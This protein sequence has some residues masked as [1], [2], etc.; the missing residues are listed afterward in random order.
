MLLPGLTNITQ[1]S[2]VPTVSL[3]PH[4]PPLSTF[5]NSALDGTAQTPAPLISATPVIV[6]SHAPLPLSQ[7]PL[8]AA[9]ICPSAP[10]VSQIPRPRTAAQVNNDQ[11]VTRTDLSDSFINIDSPQAP[12]ATGAST[13]NHLSTCEALDQL[14]TAAAQIT[15]NVPTVQTIDQIIG[16]ASDQFQAQQLCVQREIQE[17]VESTNARFAALAEQMQQLISTIAAAAAVRNRPTPRLSPVTSRFHGEETRN[18]Y[19]PNET[20]CETEPAQ[21]FCRP[22]IHDKPKAPSTDTL[23][24]NKF[25]CTTRREEEGSHSAPLRRLQPVANTFAFSDYPPDDYYDHP[26]PRYELPRTSHGEEDSRIKT[27]V[28]NMHRLTINGAATN[29]RLLRFFIRMENEF[30]Y[31]AS[32]HIKMS[33]LRWLSRDMPSDMIQD[34]TPYEDASHPYMKI[35]QA[36]AGEKRINNSLPPTGTRKWMVAC[37]EATNDENKGGQ[38]GT[39]LVLSWQSFDYEFGFY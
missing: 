37:G 2:V 29:K 27:I 33:A 14:S 22:P 24:N 7:D 31:D 4:N 20:P 21:A 1:S 25:S 16:T 9:V 8:I 28:D 15:N 36:K 11:T 26:Q 30:R 19:I 6:N 5:S 10:A 18:I 35:S 38:W 13:N 32:N 17:Q 23:Y 39:R 12:A 34:M 3:S